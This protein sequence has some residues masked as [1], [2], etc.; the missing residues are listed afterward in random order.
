MKKIPYRG[1]YDH[2]EG[3]ID[4]QK[5]KEYVAFLSDLPFATYIP[6]HDEPISKEEIIEV[7]SQSC[8]EK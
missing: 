8:G 3:K 4:P 5:M 2:G 6:G 1:D 7:L